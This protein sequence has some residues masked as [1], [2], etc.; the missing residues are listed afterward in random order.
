MNTVLQVEK[1]IPWQDWL[2]AASGIIL[3]LSPFVFQFSERTVAW[4]AYAAGVAI[5]VIAAAAI[6]KRGTWP[7]VFLLLLGIWLVVSP[8]ILE[9]S[10]DSKAILTTIIVGGLVFICAAWA[11]KSEKDTFQQW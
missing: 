5:A 3:F 1:R 2:M 10:T 11:M 7:E 6:R 4:N 9:F 8:W